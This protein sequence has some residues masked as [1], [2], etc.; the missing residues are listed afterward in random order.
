[1]LDQGLINS[2]SYKYRSTMTIGS[3][4]RKARLQRNYT[5]KYMAQNL[6]M[7]HANYG[8]IENGAIGIS[9]ERTEKIAAILAVTMEEILSWPVETSM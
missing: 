9:R 7:S 3:N 6:G 2:N 5:Q 4:I 8:K 1:M